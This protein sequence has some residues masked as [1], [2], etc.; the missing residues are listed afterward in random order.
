MSILYC[1]DDGESD[2]SSQSGSSTY[3]ALPKTN[4]DR[5][6]KSLLKKTNTTNIRETSYIE[7]CKSDKDIKLKTQKR[8]HSPVF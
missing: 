3:K 1:D 8:P 4:Q 7:L 5:R 6:L 2:C